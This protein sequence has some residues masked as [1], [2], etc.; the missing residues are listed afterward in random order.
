MYPRC[1]FPMFTFFTN[2]PPNHLFYNFARSPYWFVVIRAYLFVGVRIAH[3]PSLKLGHVSCHQAPSSF[4]WLWSW[5]VSVL[6]N[7][8]SQLNMHERNY[9]LSKVNLEP[10]QK[11]RKNAK[12]NQSWRATPPRP[13]ST[14]WCC[15]CQL[16][17]KESKFTIRLLW[18]DGL[19]GSL[20]L[21]L[22]VKF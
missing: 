15:F 7:F 22:L 19:S 2:C 6:R 4:V 3:F 11:N 1:L 18:R 12:T 17:E 14:F 21:K 9:M 13:L 5:S 20:T 8:Y 10:H 16:C